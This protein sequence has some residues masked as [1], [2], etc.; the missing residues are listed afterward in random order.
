MILGYSVWLAAP[1]L[2]TSKQRKTGESLVII[3]QGLCENLVKY[4]LRD[5]ANFGKFE[6]FLGLGGGYTWIEEGPY[7]SNNTGKAPL[8]LERFISSSSWRS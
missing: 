3:L 5:L 4:S 1:T 7:N 2:E 8:K 6:P